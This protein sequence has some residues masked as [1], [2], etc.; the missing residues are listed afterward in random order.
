MYLKHKQARFSLAMGADADL[1]SDK[2]VTAR[3]LFLNWTMCFTY[4]VTCFGVQDWSS[5]IYL[6]VQVP[7][8]A[9]GGGHQNGGVAH[10]EQD[11]L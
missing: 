3:V 4:S 10:Q 9:L 7:G 1:I 5:D 8:A 2:K 11:A 6:V